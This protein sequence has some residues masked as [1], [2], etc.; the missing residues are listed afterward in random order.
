MLKEVQ[1]ILLTS[2]EPI[3]PKDIGN[4]YRFH[5]RVDHPT[6]RCLRMRKFIQDT[7]DKGLLKY[8]DKGKTTSNVIMVLHDPLCEQPYNALD[9]E[10][11]PTW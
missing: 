11:V 1:I 7:F 4:Y 10:D 6:A 2:K 8:E 3:C 9:A 5:Q